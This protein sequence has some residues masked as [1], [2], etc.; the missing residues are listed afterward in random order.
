MSA[1]NAALPDMVQIGGVYTPPALR[2]H[3]YGRA[4]VAGSLLEARADGVERSI[5]FTAAGNAPAQRAYRALGYRVVGRYGV[6][7][8][9]EP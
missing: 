8:F 9:A 3:G 1:F 7:V 2:G 6:V 4:V 5:L